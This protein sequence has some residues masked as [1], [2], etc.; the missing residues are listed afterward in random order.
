MPIKKEPFVRYKLD[1]DKEDK[2]YTVVSLKLNLDDQAELIKAQKVLN[3]SKVSTSIK[4]LMKIGLKVVLDEK[5]KELINI[6][7]SNIKKNKKYGNV[8]FD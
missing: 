6:I 7:T 3:Q 1:E 4:Q 8:D 2:N 5:N